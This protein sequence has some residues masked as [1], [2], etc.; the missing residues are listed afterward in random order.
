M[1]ESMRMQTVDGV[2]WGNPGLSKP[3]HGLLLSTGALPAMP[4]AV[5]TVQSF[6]V[7]MLHTLGRLL[8]R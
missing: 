1:N 6:D 2:G 5:E 4:L 8:A 7:L 3:D